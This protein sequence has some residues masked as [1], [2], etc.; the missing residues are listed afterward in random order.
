LAWTKVA[1]ASDVEAGQMRQIE[2]EDEVLALYHTQDNRWYA[3]SDAC[4]H[5]GE[6]LTA[7]TLNGC[8][9]GC[10]KHGGKFDVSNG[11][12]IAMPCVVPVE[13]FP[14][15]VRGDEVYLDFD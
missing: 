12:A 3:T 8:V 11:N 5:A 15:E 4:T 10:P 9:V 13:T 14:V 1:Y 7:G 6:S 2:V